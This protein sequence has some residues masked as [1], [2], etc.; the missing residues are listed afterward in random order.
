MR[1]RAVERWT[2]A[3]GIAGTVLSIGGFSMFI[4]RAGFPPS[5]DTEAALAAFLRSQNANIQTG[6]LLFFVA[7]AV[8]FVFFAGLRAL[9]AEASPRLEYLATAIFGLGVATLAQ[10]F[11]FMGMEAAATA[12]ALTRPDNSVIYGLFMGG[13]VLDGAPVAVTIAAFLGLS[14]WA[15]YRSRFLSRWAG[16]LSWVMAIV[17]VATLPALYQGDYLAGIY[18]A[19]GL[20]ADVLVFVPLYV[21]TLAV[22]IAIVRKAPA[23]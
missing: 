1:D 22:S 6:V 13:S 2:G 15:L 14:G 8:W 3:A 16:W 4:F 20:V 21:W 11:I 9:I 5:A 10:F 12:N 23:R 7:F 18:S 17:V 19:D